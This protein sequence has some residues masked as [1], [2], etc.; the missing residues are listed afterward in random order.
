[1]SS[2]LEYREI[3]QSDVLVDF[4][5][6]LKMVAIFCKKNSYFL[7]QGCPH[8]VL[9]GSCPAGFRCFSASTHMIQSNASLAGL[10]R[11]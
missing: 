8:P 11:T 6:K 1:M 4:P 3:S 9:E 5:Y 2:Q 7:P 10:C